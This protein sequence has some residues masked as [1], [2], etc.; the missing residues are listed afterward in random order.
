M[1]C[2]EKTLDEIIDEYGL[3]VKPKTEINQKYSIDNYYFNVIDTQNKAYSLGMLYADGTVSKNKTGFAIS[4][5][6][7][8][9]DVLDQLNHEFGGDR[10][11]SY[12]EYSK[13]NSNWQNQ[14]M[15]GISNKQMHEDLIKHGC[16]PNKSLVLEFPNDIESGLIRH[17]V[18][19]Y[20]EGDGNISKNEDRCTLISTNN[21]C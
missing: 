11:L 3:Y 15:L 10:K 7:R 18:R 4:L 21:F 2:G 17:F 1:H 5:Q 20:F 13:K 19:G 12:I 16:V 9:K 6:E 14:Y 8:D